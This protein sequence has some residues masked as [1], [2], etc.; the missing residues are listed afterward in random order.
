MNIVELAAALEAAIAPKVEEHDSDRAAMRDFNPPLAADQIL[1]GP[2]IE[3]GEDRRAVVDEARE[4]RKRPRV[5][6]GPSRLT[7]V[8]PKEDGSTAEITIEPAGED[9]WLVLASI[10]MG[11]GEGE[12]PST[13]QVLALAE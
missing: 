13:E 4:T 10:E 1:T 8:L 3:L 7:L 2:G 5:I 11:P 6:P 9:Q 12:I